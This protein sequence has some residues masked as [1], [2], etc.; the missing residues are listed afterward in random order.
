MMYDLIGY[1]QLNHGQYTADPSETG[2]RP[3][4]PRLFGKQPHPGLM[5]LHDSTLVGE[6]PGKSETASCGLVCG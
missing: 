5:H 6:T 4:L 1:G 3:L 2:T